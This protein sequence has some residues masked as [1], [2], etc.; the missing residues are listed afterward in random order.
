M[1]LPPF[2]IPITLL[3]VALLWREMRRR[4]GVPWHALMLLAAAVWYL[5]AQ[6]MGWIR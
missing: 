4:R 1:D 3:L 6:A 2:T 5:A